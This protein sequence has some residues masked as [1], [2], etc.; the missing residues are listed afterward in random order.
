HIQLAD[1]SKEANKKAEKYLLDNPPQKEL[2]ATR[3]GKL[4][5]DIKKHLA[6]EMKEIDKLV[7]KV[8]G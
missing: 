3:L 5:L 2:T 4:R 7:K 1:L 6:A 8:V